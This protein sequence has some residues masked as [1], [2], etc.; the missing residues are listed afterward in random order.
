MISSAATSLTAAT[1]ALSV[2]LMPRV[3][4]GVMLPPSICRSCL[5]SPFDGTAHAGD[6]L[7]RPLPGPGDLQHRVE[8][9]A[10]RIRHGILARRIQPA[11]VLEA[12]RDEGR[13]WSG[14]AWVA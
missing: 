9:V 6:L 13:C 1:T 14:A 8:Q 5:A 11:A 4:V 7:A 12:V 10:P 3:G 2:A